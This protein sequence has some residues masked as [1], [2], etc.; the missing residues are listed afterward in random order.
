MRCND[1]GALYN[2]NSASCNSNGAL[3][4]CNSESCNSN[5]IG[6]NAHH[7]IVAVCSAAK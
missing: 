2:S 3:K 7:T 6:N 1:N 5:G 4:I